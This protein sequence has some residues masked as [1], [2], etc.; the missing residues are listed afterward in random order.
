MMDNGLDPLTVALASF[1]AVLVLVGGVAI[2]VSSRPT[3]APTAPAVPLPPSAEELHRQR[4]SEKQRQR[5]QETK[6]EQLKQI[7]ARNFAAQMQDLQ[8]RNQRAK[9]QAKRLGTTSRDYGT[10]GAWSTSSPICNVKK[11]AYASP[12]E[13]EAAL[14]PYDPSNVYI[15]QHDEAPGAEEYEGAEGRS[16]NPRGGC[17]VEVDFFHGAAVM[18]TLDWLHGG[19][20]SA[21]GALAFLGVSHDGMRL[22]FDNGYQL[23]WEDGTG[24]PRIAEAL[25]NYP[26]TLGGKWNSVRVKLAR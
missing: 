19:A 17:V 20:D 25:V 14:G 16:F 5:Q 22:A 11:L 21:E 2:W 9:K 10:S 6:D 4:L 1:L 12:E 23:R 24:S 3:P 8:W 18:F 13:V 15:I 7:A 26:A